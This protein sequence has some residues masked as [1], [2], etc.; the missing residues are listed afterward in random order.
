MKTSPHKEPSSLNLLTMLAVAVAFGF[1]LRVVQLCDKITHSD[2][3]ELPLDAYRHS[4]HGIASWYKASG[5][6]CA[7]RLYPVGTRLLVKHGG[8]PS[9]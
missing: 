1:A 6:V 4:H 8:S 2:P 9:W 3:Q 7:C 5:M